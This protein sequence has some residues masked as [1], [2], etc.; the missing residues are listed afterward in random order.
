MSKV[1]SETTTTKQPAG[2]LLF[3]K[4][5]AQGPV[6]RR[7]GQECTANS[8]RLALGRSRVVSLVKARI[9]Q[10]EKAGRR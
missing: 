7:E 6:G 8:F 4:E 3:N 5:D 1:E 2:A 9:K 10:L